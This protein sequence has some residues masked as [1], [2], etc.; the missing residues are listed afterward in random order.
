[1]WGILP[2]HTCYASPK[3]SAWWILKQLWGE[4]VEYFNTAS[5]KS[6]FPIHSSGT[7]TSTDQL[8]PDK[9]QGSYIPAQLCSESSRFQ[10][11]KY[12]SLF[13]EREK[14]IFQDLIFCFLIE[15]ESGRKNITNNLTLCPFLLF[16]RMCWKPDRVPVWNRTLWMIHIGGTIPYTRNVGNSWNT[17][18]RCCKKKTRCHQAMRWDGQKYSPCPGFSGGRYPG[19]LIEWIL[20]WIESSQIKII[21]S[22]F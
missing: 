8:A 17:E 18:N 4:I 21:E 6:C 22:I 20:Y 5:L 16:L 7:S 19:F 15:R 12:S 11:I 1:M 13:I 14:I 10:P 9:H 2:H 3:M